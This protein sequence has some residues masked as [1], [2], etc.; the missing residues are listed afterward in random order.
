V[1]GQLTEK[2]DRSCFSIKGFTDSSQFLSSLDTFCHGLFGKLTSVRDTKQ[3]L[4]SLLTPGGGK[5]FRRTQTN[6]SRPVERISPACLPPISA[7][8]FVP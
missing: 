4:L 2:G 8:F 3:P 6:C 7:A 1:G 5:R